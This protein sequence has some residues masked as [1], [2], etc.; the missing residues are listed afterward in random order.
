MLLIVTAFPPIKLN[1]EK[2]VLTQIE[3]S[4]LTTLQ[5]ELTPPTLRA[6]EATPSHLFEVVDDVAVDGGAEVAQRAD[7]RHLAGRV[8]TAHVRAQPRARVVVL[9]T[10]A[11]HQHVRLVLVNLQGTVRGV[12]FSG[13]SHNAFPVPSVDD[14]FF[15]NGN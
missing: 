14:A 1:R 5:F 7:V 2:C 6:L 10:D 13:S 15:P 9:L 4:P 8:Q 3:A 12:T 11:T